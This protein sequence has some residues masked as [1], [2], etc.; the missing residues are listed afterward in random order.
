MSQMTD[1]QARFDVLT[2]HENGIG[3]VTH[4]S[5]GSISTRSWIRFDQDGATQNRQY[6][7][8]VMMSGTFRDFEELSSIADDLLTMRHVELGEIEWLLTEETTSIFKQETRQ[9]AVRDA[10]EIARRYAATIDKRVAVKA[11]RD[12]ACSQDHGIRSCHLKML[13]EFKPLMRRRIT[14]VCHYGWK[15]SRVCPLS[16]SPFRNK[17]VNLARVLCFTE[18]LMC[19]FRHTPL[20]H[21]TRHVRS[22]FVRRCGQNA[23]VTTTP[24]SKP[25]FIQGRPH[26][27]STLAAHP[28][29]WQCRNSCSHLIPAD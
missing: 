10:I 8:N 7:A 13:E 28:L 17:S 14:L 5:M 2:R 29:D 1:V 25:A 11:I 24:R 22:D 23:F 21:Q 19:S 27:R 4:L 3:K 15:M 9:D 6:A 18:L 20:Q 12:Q 26:T 16:L